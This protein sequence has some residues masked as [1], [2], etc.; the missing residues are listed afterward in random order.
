MK[1]ELNID[2]TLTFNIAG[3]AY[4]VKVKDMKPEALVGLLMYG[5]RKANDTYNS[6]K[7][8]ESPLEPDEVIEKIK[9]WDF[10]SGGMRV[11]P[12]VKAQREIVKGY[13]MNAGLKSKDAT[14]GAKEP[15]KGF[16]QALALLI[17]G[18]RNV[19]VK[20]VSEA[21]INAAFETNWPSVVKQA[22]DMVKATQTPDIEI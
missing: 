1:I 13:L 2:E 21:D 9:A 8:G 20:D 11:S 3:E 15:E 17:A 7:G 10:G 4:P 12:F 14:A 16:K 22:E 6:A 18:K 5:K 19:L